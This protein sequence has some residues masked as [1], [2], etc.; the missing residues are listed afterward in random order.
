MNQVYLGIGSNKNHPY[1]RINTVLKQINRIKSTNIVKKSSLY[2]TKP[3]GP[4][5][6]PDF[7]NSVIEIRTNLEPLKLLHELQNLERLHNR[8]KTKRWG[9]RSMDIDILIYNNLIMNTDKL[10]IPHPGLEYRDFVLMPLYEITSYRFE[11][12]KYGKIITLIKNLS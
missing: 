5:A 6:Q 2:V 9:P 12:P 1:F 10:V 8:K 11:I 4:Q 7:I 3:L